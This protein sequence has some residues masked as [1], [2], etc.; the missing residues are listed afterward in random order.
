MVVQPAEPNLL[1]YNV[2]YA[3]FQSTGNTNIQCVNAL[4]KVGLYVQEQNRGRGNEKRVWGIETNEA[5]ELYL[6]LYGG[7]DKLD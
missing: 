7:V 3:S 6:K 1:F 5:K 2:V 4:N